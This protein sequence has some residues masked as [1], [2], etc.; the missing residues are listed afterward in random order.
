M[1][2]SWWKKVITLLIA[3]LFTVAVFLAWTSYN[4]SRQ[5]RD[6]IVQENSAS[7][8][9]WSNQMTS[10]VNAIYEHVYELL[11]TL[12][13]N[14]E[15]RSDTPIMN[16]RTKI[17]IIDMMEEKLLVSEDADAFFVY[18]SHNDFFLFSAKSSLSGP[19]I[20]GLKEF[21]R[22][23][24]V[25]LREQ[26]GSKTWRIVSV[27]GSDY[28]FKSVQLGKYTV[29]TVS[30]TKYYAIEDSYSVLGVEPVCLLSTQDGEFAFGKSGAGEERDSNLV[31]VC[32]AVP[33]LQGEVTL[34]VRPDT[35]FGGGNLLSLLLI[36]D[37]ALCVVL[38]IVLLIVLNRDVA[39]ATRELVF[40]NQALASGQKDYRLD[41]KTAGSQEFAILYQ[42]FNDMAEQ[43]LRLRIE[44]YDMAIREEEN[45]LSMLR[46]QIKPHSFLNAITTISNMTYASRPEEIR[47][48]IAS[49]ARYVRYMLNMSSPWTTVA[50]ELDHIRNYLKMQETRFPGSINCT[51]D[52]PPELQ[53]RPIPFLLLFTLVENSFKHAMTLYEP[54]GIT[55]TCQ[56]VEEEN[57]SGIRLVEEDTGSGFTQE[58]LDKLFE[59]NPDSLF[60]K[61]HLGLTN[62][63]YTLKL[64]YHRNDL[65]RI[66][67][68]EGGGAHIEIRI[69]DQEENS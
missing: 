43:I 25:E 22:G 45:K 29:G 40:A 55:I 59:T 49:F 64:I 51:M 3:I 32:A 38:V 28:L 1:F 11:I 60:V 18:D 67:N 65:L 69:P 39:R 30:N 20:L 47:A 14:T 4:F 16:A 46:A 12:Y 26:F 2:R 66:S 53:S 41:P 54:L 33:V 68:R 8:K 62:V 27:K 34:S 23:N 24:A 31:T 7:L 50:G 57:F 58:A 61:E 52:C 13:N 6:T 44:A 36:L 42:S 56:R 15:L 9:M 10:R 5:Y 35:M 37:S 21:T 19:E 17:K 48:Y 63:R